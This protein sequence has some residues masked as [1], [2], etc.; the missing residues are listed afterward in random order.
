VAAIAPRVPRAIAIEGDQSMIAFLDY[1]DFVG[2]SGCKQPLHHHQDLTAVRSSR[3]VSLCRYYSFVP[4]QAPL[5]REIR[6][7][8]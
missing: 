3:I 4:Q 5:A 6:G 2:L 7:L 8:S 1:F